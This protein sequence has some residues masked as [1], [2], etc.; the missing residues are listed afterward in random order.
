LILIFYTKNNYKVIRLSIS[1][2]NYKLVNLM[3]IVI[4]KLNLKL[5]AILMVNLV[6]ALV[7]KYAIM[8]MVYQY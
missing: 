6:I 7:C 1:I 8:I 2:S 5:K 4:L 3:L